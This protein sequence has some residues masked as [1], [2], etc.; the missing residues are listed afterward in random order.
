MIS[1]K[2]LLTPTTKTQATQAILD[3][4]NALG[5]NVNAWQSGRAGR[6]LIA[7]IATLYSAFTVLIVQVVAA[8]GFLSTAAGVWLR[9]LAQE[10]FGVTW[11]PATFATGIQTLTNNAAVPYTFSPG[12]LTFTTG[13]A[14]SPVYTNTYD[15]TIYG[16]APGIATINPGQTLN[17]PIQAKVAGSK[18]NVSGGALV[19]M[20]PAFLQVVCTNAAAI[21][22]NDDETDPALRSRCEAKRQALSPNG[23]PGAYAYWAQS[24][25]LDATGAPV[26]PPPVSDQATYD[27]A[28]PIDV[29]RVKV[30]NANDIGQVHVYLGGS[31]GAATSTVVG[32]VD[33]AL[34]R[35]VVPIGIT[36]FTGV[37]GGAAGCFVQVINIQYTAELDPAFGVTPDQAAAAISTALAAYFGDPLRIFIEGKAKVT[38]GQGYVYRKNLEGVITGALPAAGLPPAIIAADVTTPANDVAIG[39]G[40]LPELGVIT[41]TITSVPQN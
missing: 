36:L 34:M 32:I 27:A 40:T 21:T 5:F 18:S 28:T 12:G 4:G 29:N 26:Y 35:Y 41:P 3:I 11:N 22:A 1:L 31:G 30:T 23:A 17:I 14:N 10:F 15:S 37:S 7:I 9:L 13:A 39:I 38:H 16:P 6:V 25:R 2:D 24:I 33:T 20:N 19:V 8:G